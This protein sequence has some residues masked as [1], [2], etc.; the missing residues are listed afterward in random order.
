VTLPV[1]VLRELV[2]ERFG[3]SEL[4]TS[5][6]MSINMIGAAVAAPLAGASADRFGRRPALIAAAFALDAL[7]FLLLTREV[8]FSAFLAVR[9]AE[10]C[11]HIV[12][13]SLL[14]GLAAGARP[15]AG[16]G[17]TLG[18]TGSGLL[19]GVALGAPLGGVLGRSDPERPLYVGA[20]VLLAASL[21]ALAA[22]RETP[23]RGASRPRLAEVAAL[24]RANRLVAFP[25]L[26]SFADR[27][28][29][30]FFT[31]TLSLFLR[32]VHEMPPPR[33]GALIAT[34]MLPFALLSF[35]FALLSQRTSRVLFLCGGSVVY[36]ALVASLG[37]W[38][39]DGLWLL[40]PATGIAAAVMF[41]PSMLL[42]T[43]T[44]PEEVRTTSLGAFNAAGSL[45]FIAGPLTGGAVS[46]AVAAS[47]GW[48]AGYRAAFFVAGASVLVLALA[49][50]APLRRF[51]RRR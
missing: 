7:C 23:R 5:L 25:L 15:A 4:A 2:Q 11:A 35:P 24:L 49:A 3:V 29:V 40:M 12:A 6:F 21:L 16:R 30:G 50:W 10:G 47:H 37:F 48:L 43:E 17:A 8:P 27:F 9:F 22:L 20:A 34:F 41:V 44:T 45:G 46:Q 39:A 13:L 33:I 14:M 1:P 28:T 51:E 38:S 18:V 26:F 42:T 31:S 36:G 32:G 19:L